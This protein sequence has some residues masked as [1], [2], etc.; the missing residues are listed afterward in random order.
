MSFWIRIQFLKLYILSILKFLETADKVSS[1]SKE[2]LHE[3]LFICIFI[4]VFPWISLANLTSPGSGVRY[5][6]W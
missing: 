3:A 2:Y 5:G 6:R 1:I 4:K